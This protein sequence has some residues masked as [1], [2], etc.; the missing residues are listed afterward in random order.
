MGSGAVQES[1]GGKLRSKKLSVGHMGVVGPG[2]GNSRVRVWV[3]VQKGGTERVVMRV[4]RGG[5]RRKNKGSQPSKKTPKEGQNPGG[6]DKTTDQ[7]W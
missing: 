7:C 6:G 3:S 2:G 5:G 4:V 1:R